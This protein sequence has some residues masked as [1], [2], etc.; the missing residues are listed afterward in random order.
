MLHNQSAPIDI[1]A[2]YDRARPALELQL[3]GLHTFDTQIRRR[4]HFDSI[5]P[6]VREKNPMKAG[7]EAPS[8][9]TKRANKHKTDFD[10]SDEEADYSFALL[11]DAPAAA[12]PSFKKFSK[13]QT[14]SID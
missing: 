4:F 1:N 9:L 8:V 6:P 5:L 3:F 12:S 14:K 13:Q 2:E 10:H 7:D 11:G